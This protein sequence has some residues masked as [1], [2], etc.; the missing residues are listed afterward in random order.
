MNMEMLK[1]LYTTYDGRIGRQRFWLGI[2]GLVVVS[3]I[4]SL[5]VMP[6]FGASM[7][8]N[9]ASM[10]EA[11]EDPNEVAR[12]L[13]E[14]TTRSGWASL[15]MTLIFLVPATALLIKRRH[16]R[17]SA[18]MEVWAYMGVTILLL[19]MQALGMGYD[20]TQVGQFTV[21]T[22]NLITTVLGTIAGLLGLY[23]LVVC[24]FLKGT[25]GPNNFGPD[26]LG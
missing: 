14:A 23:L 1:S 18:G 8:S 12:L 15:V 3:L 9:P 13:N 6:L 16:D 20:L 11:V 4:V 5:I 22:P 24:G 17:N 7:F 21:P 10:I 2:L 19:L 26:P 25:E